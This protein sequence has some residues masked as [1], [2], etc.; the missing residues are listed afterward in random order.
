MTERQFLVDTN[1]ISELSRSKPN[2]LVMSFFERAARFSISVMVLHE[3]QF[4]LEV[5]NDPARRVRLTAF[6]ARVRSRFSSSALPVT[7]D[8]GDVAA[9]MRALAKRNGRVLATAD[10]LIAATSLTHGL[11]LATR[12]VRDFADLD[13]PMLNPFEAA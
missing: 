2:A 4:G 7:L 1:V 6:I 10:A 9:R 13:V 5:L 3:L 8:I 11:T 12:N